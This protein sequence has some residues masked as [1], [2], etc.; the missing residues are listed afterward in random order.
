[1]AGALRPGLRA[2]ANQWKPF[3]FIQALAVVCVLAYYQS[4]PFQRAADILQGWKV[5]GGLPFAFFAGAVAGGLVPELA[6]MAT[7]TAEGHGWS[8]WGRV[9]WTALVFGLVGV[10]V[11]AFYKVQAL[12]FGTGIDPLTLAYKTAFDMLCFS[13]FFCIPFEVVALQWPERRFRVA[14]FFRVFGW[15]AYRENVL[16][17][18]IP[19]WAFWIPVL[20]CVYAMPLNLQFVFAIFAEAAWSLIVVFVA[21]KAAA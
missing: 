21:R 7:R 8:R 1:M 11:D 10:F 13:P 20:V 3:L 2:V 4:Q 19:C 15:S 5:A 6:K 14:E 18:L 12:I 16:P 9:F 17:A